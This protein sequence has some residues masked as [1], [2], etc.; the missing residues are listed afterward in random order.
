MKSIFIAA[1]AVGLSAASVSAADIAARPYTKAPLAPATSWTG[2]YLSGGGGYGIA[3]QTVNAIDPSSGPGAQIDSGLKGYFGTVSAGY[4]Y[5]FASHWVGGV[6]ASYDVSDIHGTES[7]GYALANAPIVGRDKL[8][9]TLAVGGRIGWLS[10]PKTLWFLSGGYS[11]AHFSSFGVAPLGFIGSAP[12]PDIG[13]RIGSRTVNGWFVGAGTE[14]KLDFLPFLPGDNWFVRAEYRY[15]EYDRNTTP[16]LTSIGGSGPLLFGYNSAVQ[17]VRTELVYK[18]NSGGGA[19][20]ASPASIPVKAAV[21][22]P[23]WTGF[24]VGGGGGYGFA[25]V[26]QSLAI[27]GIGQTTGYDGGARG[28]FGTVSAGFDYQFTPRIVGGVLANYDF[29]SIKGKFDS[30]LYISPQLGLTLEQ[31]LKSSWAVGGRLG[32]LATPS[33]LTYVS[34]GYTEAEFD[35]STLALVGFPSGAIGGHTHQGYFLGSGLESKLDFLPGK[36]W[37]LKTEYRYV[38]YSAKSLDIGGAA[39]EFKPIVQT[40]RMEL[41]YKFNALAPVVA[42]Y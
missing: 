32:W 4:D 5:Q 12:A 39:F 34:A 22:A 20:Y 17:S 7:L 26:K 25:S 6:F 40:V 33:T 31:K 35:A 37:S 11:Q 38:D 8:N 41:S 1:A 9:S 19:T 10:D 23:N 16:F 2:F 24:Y 18:F 30:S 13:S 27:F 28:G 15:A 14:S 21:A 36:N 3:N 42:K 29:A